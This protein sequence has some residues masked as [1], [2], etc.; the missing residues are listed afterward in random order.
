[1]VFYFY[2]A[3]ILWI[4]VQSIPKAIAKATALL[5]VGISVL[6]FVSR[7]PGYAELN[8]QIEEY[9]SASPYIESNTTVLGLTYASHGYD[10]NPERWLVKTYLPFEHISGLLAADKPVVD[11]SNYESALP[12]FWT[13]Y[14]PEVDPFRFVDKVRKSDGRASAANLDGYPPDSGGRIDYVLFWG[15]DEK[16]QRVDPPSPL[17]DQ[18]SDA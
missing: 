8:R 4:S 18:L 3:L 15:L 10:P 17:R 12:I 2:F 6:F 11:L 14:R 7:A 1:M 13:R 16:R 5:A 9:L